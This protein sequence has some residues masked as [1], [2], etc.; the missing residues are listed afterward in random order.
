VTGAYPGSALLA[1]QNPTAAIVKI[2]P[3]MTHACPEYSAADFSVNGV[4][5]VSAFV[6][7]SA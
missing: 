4:R 6:V 5:I 7:Y 3:S 1:I 2:T